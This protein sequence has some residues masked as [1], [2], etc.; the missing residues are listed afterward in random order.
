MRREL[1]RSGRARPTPKRATQRCIGSLPTANSSSCAKARRAASSSRA[2]MDRCSACTP[3][4][5]RATASWPRESSPSRPRRLRPLRRARPPCT[6]TTRCARRRPHR[7]S[8]RARSSCSRRTRCSR[9]R[10]RSAPA[11]S[12]VGR[13]RRCASKWRSSSARGS[14]CTAPGSSRPFATRCA[15]TR[16]RGRTTPTAAKTG[17]SS[18]HRRVAQNRT[19]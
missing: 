19:A 7:V 17:F 2:V 8:R 9:A 14:R 12:R 11:G 18:A 6:S 5:S 3:S 13:S 1:R 16:A 15:G 4:S 10:R